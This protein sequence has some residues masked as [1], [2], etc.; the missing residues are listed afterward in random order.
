MAYSRGNS[1]NIIVGAAAFFI[2]DAT[3]TDLPEAL[4]EKE[5]HDRRLLH[6]TLL[7][8]LLVLHQQ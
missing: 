1:N 6:L 3:L 7:V 4:D 2:A 8:D 5:S